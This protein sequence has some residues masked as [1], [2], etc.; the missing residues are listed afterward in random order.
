MGV[1]RTLREF[2][3]IGADAVVACQVIFAEADDSTMKL[4]R[5]PVE[6]LTEVLVAIGEHLNDVGMICLVVGLL[7]FFS[8]EDLC[9]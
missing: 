6:S 3:F 1:G 5:M 4:A 8:G 2:S 9:L 7:T